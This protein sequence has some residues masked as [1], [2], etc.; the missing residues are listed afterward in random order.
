[1]TGRSNPHQEA[2]EVG[3]GRQVD[4]ERYAFTVRL[5]ELYPGEPTGFA[6]AGTLWLVREQ[7]GWRVDRLP[8]TYAPD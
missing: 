5:H 1:M 8:R 3:P 2:F 7:H 4:S 6:Y